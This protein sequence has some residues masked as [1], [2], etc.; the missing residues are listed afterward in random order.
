M[1]EPSVWLLQVKEAGEW[2]Y[3]DITTDREYAEDHAAGSDAYRSVELYTKDAIADLLE[4]EATDDLGGK[5]SPDDYVSQ[6]E[7]V[8]VVKCHPLNVAARR[9]R[10][11]GG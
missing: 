8:S 5:L 1:S 2:G 10:K 9:L 11:E 6:V 7:Y 3:D 4:A